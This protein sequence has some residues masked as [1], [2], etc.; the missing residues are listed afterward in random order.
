M[1]LVLFSFRA[2]LTIGTLTRE[3]FKHGIPVFVL[4]VVEVVYLVF[5]VV[6]DELISETGNKNN[7]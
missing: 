2:F 6:G 7:T 5:F 3:I 4:S 1:C